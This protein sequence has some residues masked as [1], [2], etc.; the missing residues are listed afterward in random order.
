M[1]FLLVSIFLFS[2]SFSALA[3]YDADKMFLLQ[4]TEKYRRMK[5][6]GA[7]LTVVGNILTVAG[8]VTVLNNVEETV[9]GSQT[10]SATNDKAATGAI[11]WLVGVGGMG[12]G[13]PLWAVGA[14]NY[15]KYSQKLNNVSLRFHAAPHRAGLT[16][17][18]KF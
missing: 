16:V 1:K 12:A 8:I 18:Y 15:K 4:K 7:T 14:H 13:I 9:P 5:N 2:L 11:M 3:Q 17:A 10:Y 6:T